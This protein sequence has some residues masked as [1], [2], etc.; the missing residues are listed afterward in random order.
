M[1]STYFVIFLFFLIIGS[2]FNVVLFR[3]NTSLSFAKGRS[4]C[5]S[6]GKEL[7]FF[8]NIPVVSFFIQMG[9]CRGCKTRISWQYPLVELS[10]GLVG[11]LLWAHSSQMGASFA[12]YFAASLFFFLALFLVAVYDTRTK[13]IDR[14]FLAG[15][16]LGAFAMGIVRWMGAESFLALMVQDV[17]V[18]LLL[19]LFFWGLWYFSK[20]TWM[21]RGDSDVAFVIGVALGFPES[22]L[23]ML[24]GFWIG[25]IVGVL[26]LALSRLLTR[27]K[28]AHAIHLKTEIPFAP[29]LALGA[30]GALLYGTELL[31]FLLWA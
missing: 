15:A 18:A 30:L 7:Q 23:A 21:G 6:C 13:I 25:A 2:F 11:V 8:E 28:G 29:F 27:T 31:H 9:R 17:F 4:R 1:A 3:K 5:L 12:G 10:A 16:L 20:G 14:H 26:L 19:W 24:L 22:L